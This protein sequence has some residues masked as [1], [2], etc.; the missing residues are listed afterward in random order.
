MKIALKLLGLALL[1]SFFT[2]PINAQTPDNI[3]V[4]E[5]D[6]PNEDK[7]LDDIVEKRLIYEK[8]VL[9][10]DHIREADIFWE[11]RIWRVSGCPRKN[12][13]SLRLP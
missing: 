1:V 9:P 3:I 12:E 11:K 4:T 2:G 10:Y 7:P 13:P 6:D 8:R 5:A